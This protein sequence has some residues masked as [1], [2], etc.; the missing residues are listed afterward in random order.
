MA[1]SSKKQSAPPESLGLDAFRQANEDAAGLS[2][3]QLSQAFAQMLSTGDDPYNETQPEGA[4][5]AVAIADEP[6][7]GDGEAK[8]AVDSCEVSP[9]TILEAMLFVGSPTNE[10]LTSE[11]VAS[12]MRGVRPAEIDQLVC[13]LNERY[14]EQ[15]CPY[16]I[17]SKGAGYRLALRPDFYRVRDR[18]YGRTKQA[19][20]SQASIEVLSLVAYN[21]PLSAD[22][23]NRLRATASGAILSQLVRRELLRLDRSDPEFRRG[24]YFT[25]PR[26]LQLFG[27]SSLEELPSSEDAAAV[28]VTVET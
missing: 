24:R 26:F 10:P 2:L 7:D 19:R 9:Q 15:G 6:A 11:Q 14:Q 23:V 3:D 20:L 8:D 4:Q 16:T 12:L 1:K 28:S 21:Q 17:V 5:D 22:D 18:F 13:S 27:L 25:T